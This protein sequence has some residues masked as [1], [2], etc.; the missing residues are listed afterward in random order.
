MA[1]GSSA[2]AS[3][4][5]RIEGHTDTVGTR[6]FNRML[7]Q[8]RA[9]AVVRYMGIKFGLAMSRMEPV[10]V[11]SDELL[12]PTPEQVAEPRNR[13]VRIVNLGG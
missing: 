6:E 12:I 13:R 9:D 11:G 3:Y 2:L 8:Q 4:R 5:F 1:L 10:G 7:S